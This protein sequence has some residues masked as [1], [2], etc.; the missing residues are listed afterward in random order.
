MYTYEGMRDGVNSQFSTLIKITYLILL[1]TTH[2]YIKLQS[3]P[4]RLLDHNAIL[5]KRRVIL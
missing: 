3:F 2:S 5:V 1:L 4:Y